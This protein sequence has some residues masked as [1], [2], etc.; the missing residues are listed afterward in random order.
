[1]GAHCR[2][3]SSASG[4]PLCR[5]KLSNAGLRAI[6]ETAVGDDTVPVHRREISISSWS[7]T[8]AS[9]GLIF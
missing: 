7:Q 6:K 8:I 1:M 9:K 4:H 5:S 3:R 2:F